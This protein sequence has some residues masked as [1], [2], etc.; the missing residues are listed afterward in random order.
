M[1]LP[2]GCAVE[3]IGPQTRTRSD[4]IET[5]RFVSR[6]SSP[7]RA[8]GGLWSIGQDWRSPTQTAGTS[9]AIGPKVGM[10]SPVLNAGSSPTG[11]AWCGHHG[12]RTPAFPAAIEVMVGKFQPGRENL[13]LGADRSARSIAR[14]F[15][16]PG[17]RCIGTVG[18]KSLRGSPVS[19]PCCSRNSGGSV[20]FTAPKGRHAGD[21]VG[22]DYE[23]CARRADGLREVDRRTHVAG[24]H[25]AG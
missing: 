14:F 2:A 10:R 7:I 25:P 13:D 24:A 11:E 1:V 3:E 17:S 4:G 5:G 16:D 9:A 22:W 8:V 23:P 6:P 20:S 15:R 21:A 18:A 19:S 12:L